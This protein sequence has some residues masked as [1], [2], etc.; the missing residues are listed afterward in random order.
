MNPETRPEEQNP[1]T[2]V[3][4]SDDLMDNSRIVATAKAKGL[5]TMSVRN[6]SKFMN[7][8][9]HINGCIVID[10]EHPEIDYDQLSEFIHNSKGNEIRIIAFAPH[11]NINSF[12]SARA[13][14]LSEVFPRSAFFS[15]LEEQIKN[16]ATQPRF[17]KS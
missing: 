14:G 2:V 11:V 17:S 10:L 4:F 8:I 3:V 9:P 13:A 7:L 1:K 16:W 12:Q 6:W 15:S 5:A